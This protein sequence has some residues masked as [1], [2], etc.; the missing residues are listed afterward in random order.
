M[1]TVGFGNDIPKNRGQVLLLPPVGV[2]A[3]G[4][5]AGTARPHRAGAALPRLAR[6]GARA[7]GGQK[8]FIGTNGGTSSE[9]FE[10]TNNGRAALHLPQ[11]ATLVSATITYFPVGGTFAI[12]SAT[13]PAAG[14]SANT[15]PVPTTLGSV[16]LTNTGNNAPA[17]LAATIT[18][19][20]ST[21]VDNAKAY[22][23]W[24]GGTVDLV[25]VRLTYTVSQV[26]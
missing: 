9:E 20:A 23:L 24:L 2:L 4:C 1:L 6:R 7:A 17:Y 5:P 16:T 3:P 22:Y 11:G 12:R 8:F 13:V 14:A 15:P 18:L 25:A 21:V 26:E 19:P 10:V